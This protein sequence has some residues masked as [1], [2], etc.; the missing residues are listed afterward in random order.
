MIKLK[1][2]DGKMENNHI[3]NNYEVPINEKSVWKYEYDKMRL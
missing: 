3:D 2:N 1:K